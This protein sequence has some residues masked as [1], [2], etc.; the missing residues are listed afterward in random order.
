[1]ASRPLWVR[2]EGVGIPAEKLALIFERFGQA[3]GARYGGLGLGLTISQG[4]I[5]QHGGRI[6][7]ESG[8]HRGRGKHLPRPVAPAASRIGL[9]SRPVRMPWP[10][11][12]AIR[13]SRSP[14]SRKGLRA[15]R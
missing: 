7:A 6:W 8:G 11:A 4:I 14:G 3:H 5:A 10:G 1:M 13:A 9:T 12:R 15:L 2:D